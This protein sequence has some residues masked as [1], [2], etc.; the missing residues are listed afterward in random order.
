M[1]TINEIVLHIDDDQRRLRL[2][3]LGIR[4]VAPKERAQLASANSPSAIQVYGF[5]ESFR[6]RL[7]TPTAGVELNRR[8]GRQASGLR[9]HVAREGVCNESFELL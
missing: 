8:A 5:S 9:H 6:M 1:G 4:I 3:L 7:H 2:E